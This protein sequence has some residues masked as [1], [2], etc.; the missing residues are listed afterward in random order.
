MKGGTRMI[1]ATHRE[2]VSTPELLSMANEGE[3]LSER[4]WGEMCL[5][6][7]DPHVHSPENFVDAQTGLCPHCQ[8]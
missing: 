7:R 5:M 2:V 8:C 1:P 6:L 4:C 3:L